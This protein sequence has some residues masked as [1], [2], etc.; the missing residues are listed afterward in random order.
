MPE[1]HLGSAQDWECLGFRQA[2][3]L[4]SMVCTLISVCLYPASDAADKKA[5]AGL[6]TIC[7]KVCYSLN[8]WH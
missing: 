1:W 3:I 5:A 2:V 7:D 4:R 8:T 6:I